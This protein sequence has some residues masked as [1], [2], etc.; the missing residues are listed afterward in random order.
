MNN[1]IATNYAVT[2]KQKRYIAKRKME[3]DGIKNFCKHSFSSIKK[4]DFVTYT[5]NPSYF[6][7]NW[8]AYTEEV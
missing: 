6:A 2:R 1:R 8:R 3:K 4:G 5:R 7:K